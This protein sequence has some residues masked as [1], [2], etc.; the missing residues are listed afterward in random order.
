MAVKLHFGIFEAVGID[1][2]AVFKVK[3]YFYCR[4]ANIFD[5]YIFFI[6]VVQ[7]SIKV[8]LQFVDG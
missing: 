5:F 1:F 8:E 4:V 3:A 7:G 6:N 2:R